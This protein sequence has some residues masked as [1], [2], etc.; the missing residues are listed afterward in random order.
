MYKLIGAVIIVAVVAWSQESIVPARPLEKGAIERGTYKNTSLGLELTPDA[1]LKFGT[2]EL[3]GKPGDAHSSLMVMAL[4]RFRSGSAREATAFW[5]V[6]LASYPVG[7]RST[8]AVMRKI[9]KANQK[10]G[11]SPAG[12]SFAS[13]LG[14]ISFLRTDFFLREHPAYETVFVK[15]CGAFALGVVLTGSDRDA[16]NKLIAGTVLKLD[17][18]TTGCPAQSDIAV[19]N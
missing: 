9:V 13:E 18:L 19:Q 14:G 2:P 4:G 15:A 17:L 16:V 10:D 5:A 11:F 1:K 7:Q 3:K 6:P 12:G 8:D